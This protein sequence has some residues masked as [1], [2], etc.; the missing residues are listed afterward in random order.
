MVD[1]AK[2]RLEV[3][4]H[5]LLAPEQFPS[6]PSYRSLTLLRELGIFYRVSITLITRSFEHLLFELE[7]GILYYILQLE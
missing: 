2:V 4:P 1:K 6:M 5:L 3:L 7:Q